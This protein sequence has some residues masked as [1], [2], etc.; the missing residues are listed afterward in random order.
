MRTMVSYT[1]VSP[2][3]GTTDDIADTRAISC[4]FVPVVTSSLM[5][6]STRDARF[7]TVAHVRKPCR[8][9]AHGVIQVGLLHLVFEIY[10]RTSLANSAIRWSYIWVQGAY[11]PRMIPIR[12]SE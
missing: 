6:N 1:A 8:L 12:S 9:T 2:C 10:G 11:Q 3:G 7:Q 4:R 5:A